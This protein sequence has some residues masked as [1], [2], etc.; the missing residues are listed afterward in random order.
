MSELPGHEPNDAG[1]RV[2]TED[3]KAEILNRLADTLEFDPNPEVRDYDPKWYYAR[4]LASNNPGA[5][6][7]LL[8]IGDQ[9]LTDKEAFLLVEQSNNIYTKR[10]PVEGMYYKLSYGNYGRRRGA[11]VKIYKNG[12]ISF[13]ASATSE[14]PTE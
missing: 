14:D 12:R 13:S 5:A 11:G 1:I 6:E 10:G 3:E 4:E 7:I 2:Y 8:Q 9:S